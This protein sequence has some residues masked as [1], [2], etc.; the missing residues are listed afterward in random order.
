MF[1]SDIRTIYL[2]IARN[3]TFRDDLGVRLS[4]A[5]MRRIQERTPYKVTGDPGADSTLACR[6]SAV[7][8]SV[9]TE[10]GTDE[11]RAFEAI[12]SVEASWVDRQGRVLMENRI[13][14]DGNQALYFSQETRVVPEA[15][16]AL[17]SELQ[18][19]IEGLADRI[20]AQMELRW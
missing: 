9:L 7:N 17:E 1:R 10:T 12:T 18:E 13:L 4:E 5:L 15:G 6:F 16:Q 14:P 8:K 19:S 20:V 3:E 11:V 2:P